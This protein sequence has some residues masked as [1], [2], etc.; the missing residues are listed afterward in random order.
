MELRM[1]QHATALN[2][3]G[4]VQMLIWLGKQRLGQSNRAE[5]FHAGS[6]FLVITTGKMDPGEWE[7]AWAMCAAGVP[8]IQRPE[9]GSAQ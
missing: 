8:A 4:S 5:R 1:I 3:A 6:N 7:A 9:E 2:G